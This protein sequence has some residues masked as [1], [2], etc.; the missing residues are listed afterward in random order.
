M[1]RFV[2][3]CVDGLTHCELVLMD[4]SYN[5]ACCYLSGL[6]AVKSCEIVDG[7]TEIRMQSGVVFLYDEGRGLLLKKD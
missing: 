7:M 3:A 5:N 6:G 1:R 4:A 2:T